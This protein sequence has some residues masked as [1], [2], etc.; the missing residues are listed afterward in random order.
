MSE[1]IFKL[2]ILGI[3]Y[4]SVYVAKGLLIFSFT[5][6]ICQLVTGYYW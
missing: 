5:V 2:E 4:E 6:L 1:L 3:Q